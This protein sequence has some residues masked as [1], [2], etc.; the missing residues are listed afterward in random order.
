MIIN[1]LL[2]LY[3]PIAEITDDDKFASMRKNKVQVSAIQSGN[4]KSNQSKAV[5]ALA[6]DKLWMI[7]PDQPN[8]TVQKTN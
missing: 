4:M 5:D 2:S 1:Y 8:N 7:S 3:T 6:L